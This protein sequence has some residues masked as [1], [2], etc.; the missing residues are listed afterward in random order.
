MTA[1]TSNSE[2]LTTSNEHSR[3][4]GNPLCHAVIEPI[5]NGWRRTA[6]RFCS[7]DCK[8]TAWAIRRLGRLLVPLGKEQAWELLSK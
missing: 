7:S 8:L 2:P 5:N 6:K 3:G 4:C 1:Q